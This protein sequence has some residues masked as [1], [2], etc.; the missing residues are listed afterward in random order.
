MIR[1]TLTCENEHQFESWFQSSDAF[2]ALEAAGHLSCA[3]CG[4]SK[5][6]RALMAPSVASDAQTSAALSRP[7][8]D[9]EKALAKMREHVEA[10][11]D[12]VGSSFASEARKMHDGEVPERAIYGEASVEDAKKLH[13]DGIPAL[14]LPFIP[15]QKT[16]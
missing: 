11:S 10:N 15:R 7:T 4:S 14:P 13:D 12:Y 6:S 1:Y 2:E 16:N 9:A 5:V 3:M 8:N